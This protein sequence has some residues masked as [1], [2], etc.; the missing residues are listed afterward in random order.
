MKIAAV[1]FG[2]TPLLLAAAAYGQSSQPASAPGRLVGPEALR[3]QLTI[4]I[5]IDENHL[6]VQENW[7]IQNPSQGT[8]SPEA[9]VFDLGT[10]IRRATLDEDVTAFGIEEG[11][12]V[13]RGKTALGPGNHGFALSYLLDHAGAEARFDRSFPIAVT[14]G[15]LIIEE[16]DG[17]EAVSSLSL[18]SRVSDQNGLTFRIFD[19]GGLTPGQR[20]DVTFKGLP[21]RNA[22][23]RL[24]AVVLSVGAFVWMLVAVGRPRE[25][26]KGVR[27]A[28]SATAR[29]DQL[30]RALELLEE[31][32]SAGRTPEATYAKRRSELVGQLADVLRE[33]DL[34]E[35][36]GAARA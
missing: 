31:D 36:E 19:F 18:P 8:V 10:G 4:I 27:G 13:V 32:R 24:L 30:V 5:E 23:P 33:L 2:L 28:L 22:I 7:Q 35:Q 11:E 20:F 26:N 3:A 14:A 1:G 29:R 12:N 21:S 17:L 9:L 6:K 15:R 16:V 25:R 34:A